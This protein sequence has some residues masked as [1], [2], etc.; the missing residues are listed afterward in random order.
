MTSQP[1]RRQLSFQESQGLRTELRR[2]LPLLHYG[3]IMEEE[4]SNAVTKPMPR[5]KGE[6]PAAAGGE[7]TVF[8]NAAP[9]IT[10]LFVPL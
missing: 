2:G 7:V 1:L 4:Q 9:L 3:R 6:V 10:R 5:L 8:P